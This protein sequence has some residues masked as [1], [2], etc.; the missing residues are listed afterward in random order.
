MKKTLLSVLK[1]I[2]SIIGFFLV[3]SFIC[4]VLIKIAPG[5]PVRNMLGGE[6]AGITEDQLEQMREELGLND[7]IVVQYVLWL[8][9]AVHLDFGTSYMTNAEVTEELAESIVPTLV[10]SAASLVVMAAV[11]LPL[12]ILSAK[13]KGQ[14]RRQG[15]QR[16]LH[17]LYSDTDILAGTAV[18]PAFFGE[19]ALVPDDGVND[20]ERS[21]AS[22]SYTGR[23]YGSAVHQAAAGKS[24]RQHEERFR[25][26]GEGKRDPGASDFLETYFPGQ[27]DTGAYR[28]WRKPRQPAGRRGD[29]GDDI[30]V[31]GYRKTC[32]RRAE[33]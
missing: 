15:D 24:D 20:G 30:R 18:Y 13:K 4:F 6:A 9:R 23:Q 11:S 10:L 29:H 14:Y 12:G 31:P 21:C 1:K 33:Q 3:V 7:P 27:H 26:I 28:V 32:H 2:L 25:H 16:F 17:D 19:V 22:F 5:D 8:Q